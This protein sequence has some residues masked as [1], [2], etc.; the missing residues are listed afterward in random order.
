MRKF[1]II[2]A[3]SM[4]VWLCIAILV[5]QLPI[6]TPAYIALVGWIG[7]YVVGFVSRHIE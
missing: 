1:N 5:T 3:V 4:I 2:F 6:T 7:G